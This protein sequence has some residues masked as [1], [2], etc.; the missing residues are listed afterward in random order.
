MPKPRRLRTPGY[1]FESVKEPGAR[2]GWAEVERLLVEARTYW[3]GTTRPDGRPHVAPVWGVW[4]D[5]SFVFETSSKSVKARNLLANPSVALHI[6]HTDAAVIVEGT[7]G[8]TGDEALVRSYAEL[9][10][11]KYDFDVESY[12]ARPTSRVVRIAP[13]VAY[14]YREHLGQT[15]TRWEF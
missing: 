7:A 15:A 10:V 4:I 1:G 9:C 14:S 2:L 3:I 5:Q 12:L 11:I 13:R 6:D 8:V